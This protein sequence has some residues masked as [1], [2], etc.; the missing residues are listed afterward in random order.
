[1]KEF[2]I[3][4]FSSRL[5]ELRESKNIAQDTFALELDLSNSSVSRWENGLQQP[6]ISVLFKLAQYFNVSTDYL[7]GLE[8]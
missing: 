1:M 5:R 4:I 7:L 8:D 2:D 6:A 3:K